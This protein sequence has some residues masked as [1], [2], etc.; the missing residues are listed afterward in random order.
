[1][2]KKDQEYTF[3]K[4]NNNPHA[5]LLLLPMGAM[6]TKEALSSFN[7]SIPKDQSK[8]HQGMWS[9]PQ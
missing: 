9:A 2:Q 1:M 3:M 6:V 7:K 8:V 4:I 5:E